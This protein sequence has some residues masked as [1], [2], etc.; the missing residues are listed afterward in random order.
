MLGSA[1]PLRAVTQHVQRLAAV[2]RGVVGERLLVDAAE[3]QHAL[4]DDAVGVG[5]FVI[6][7]AELWRMAHTV[8]VDKHRH[9]LR[10]EQKKKKNKQTN[11]HV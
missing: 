4:R 11:K 3:H 8:A 10:N 5:L 9:A 7:D 1:L 2:A 6:A